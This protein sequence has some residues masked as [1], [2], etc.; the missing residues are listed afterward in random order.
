[1]KSLKRLLSTVILWLLVGGFLVINISWGE[2]VIIY[3][4]PSLP[5]KY[6]EVSHENPHHLSKQSL[7]VY[8]AVISVICISRCAFA[9]EP[10]GTI[11]QPLP[12]Y[13]AFLP[14]ITFGIPT[15]N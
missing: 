3:N 11:G 15:P 8:I 5:Q 2:G 4:Y 14:D 12:E 10:I 9:M 13:N 1:M 7:Q 6:L